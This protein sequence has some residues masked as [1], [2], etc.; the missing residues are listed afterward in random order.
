MTMNTYISPLSEIYEVATSPPPTPRKH[1]FVHSHEDVPMFFPSSQSVFGLSE[2]NFMKPNERKADQGDQFR[3]LSTSMKM[4]LKPRFRNGTEIKHKQTLDS[5][6]EAYSI[7][8]FNA[9]PLQASEKDP[10]NSLREMAYLLPP[11]PFSGNGDGTHS[12]STKY[13]NISGENDPHTKTST[14]RKSTPVSR[15]KSEIEKSTAQKLPAIQRSG[16]ARPVN[17]RNSMVARCA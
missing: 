1:S 4:K 3:L 11:P 7:P 14:A 16:M 13:D 8:F 2:S 5:I 10:M 12:P 9:P 17:R 15:S 6:D